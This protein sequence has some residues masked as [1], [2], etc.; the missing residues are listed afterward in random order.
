[1]MLCLNLGLALTLVTVDMGAA[2]SIQQTTKRRS[3]FNTMAY[4]VL[5][6]FS[7]FTVMVDLYMEIH[8]YM[9]TVG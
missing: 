5:Y 8:G 4:K 3:G 6:L 9:R 2:I 1:M 7:V